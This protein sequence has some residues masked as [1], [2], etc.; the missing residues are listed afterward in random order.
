MT[1]PDMGYWQYAYDAAG[2]SITQTD[3]LNQQ[4]LFSYDPLGR[5]TQKRSGSSVLATYTYNSGSN[6]KGR[7]T[8]MTDTVASPP[9]ST[10]IAGGC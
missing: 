5:L 6:G 3:A 4:L 10:I 1:D 7:R 8:G 9:G 2:R